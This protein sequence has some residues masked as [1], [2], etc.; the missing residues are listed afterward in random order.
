MYQVVV[1]TMS[2]SAAREGECGEAA[3]PGTVRSL[4]VVEENRKEVVIPSVLVQ[5]EYSHD[6]DFLHGRLLRSKI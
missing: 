6:E 5:H 1:K 2:S 4:P 3:L